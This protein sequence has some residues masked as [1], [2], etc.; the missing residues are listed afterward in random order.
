MKKI[1][2]LIVLVMSTV[3]IK[4]QTGEISGKVKD[5]KGEGMIS[6]TVIIIDAS[7]KSTGVGTVTDFDG[8]YSVKPL[9]PG[10][11]DVQYSYAGYSSQIQKGVLV[12]ADQPTFLNIKLNPADKVLNQVEVV[13]YKVPLIDKASTTN[14]TTLSKDDITN[15]AT[16]SVG[17]LVTSTSGAVET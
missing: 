4:A 16:Q 7:G 6:A 10:S 9:R 11:Y 8:N 17:D 2:T 13:A 15:M 3:L 14:A 12:K 1:L 5:E